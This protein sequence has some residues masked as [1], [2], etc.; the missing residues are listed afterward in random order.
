MT[1]KKILLAT[2]LLSAP[3]SAKWITVPTTAP[4]TVAQSKLWVTSPAGW[5]RWSKR[6]MKQSELWS[7][8]GPLLNQ[9]QFYGGVAA[10]QPLAKERNKKREPLPKFSANMKA[11]DIAEAYEQ[12]MR[13]TQGA[14]DFTIDAIEP[15]TFAGRSGFRFAYR[16]TS[17][18]LTRRGEAR[19]AIIGGKLYL[20]SYMAPALHYYD[21]HLAKA[22]AIMESAKVN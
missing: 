3:A 16:Y 8:D 4:T 20:I 15:V 13:V 9:V 1:M 7:F 12:T 14:S 10:G 6:P 11:T 5:N 22:Q 18:E 17:E 19:G 2:A 21:A